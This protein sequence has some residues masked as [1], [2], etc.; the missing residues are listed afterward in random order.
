VEPG[1]D[2][3]NFFVR[4]LHLFFTITLFLLIQLIFL[5][6][7]SI[8]VSPL[9]RNYAFNR[10]MCAAGSIT[11]TDRRR[12]DSSKITLHSVSK[13]KSHLKGACTNASQITSTLKSDLTII[14]PWYLLYR[15]APAQHRSDITEQPSAASHFR[16]ARIVCKQ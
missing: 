2:V 6:P 5:S 7:S 4:V 13:N 11:R 16:C 10:I 3:V 1:A 14:L 9:F 15:A 8:A 12:T